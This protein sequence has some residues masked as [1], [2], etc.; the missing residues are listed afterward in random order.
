MV[1]PHAHNQQP[2]LVPVPMMPNQAAAAQFTPGPNF[3]HHIPL[4]HTAPRQV[5]NGLPPSAHQNFPALPNNA[6]QMA[7]VRQ[8]QLRQL[9]NSA[10]A[11]GAMGQ[12]QYQTQMQPAIHSQQL[13]QMQQHYQQQPQQANPGLRLA[14]HPM[15]PGQ[16]LMQ[17]QVMPSS[18]MQQ[19]QGPPGPPSAR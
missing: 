9:H 8:A 3:L 18:G 15:I 2:H 13:Q 4:Q 11:P 19:I 10:M 17:Q 16:P 7:A 6:N 5:I 1:L 12:M 14:Q